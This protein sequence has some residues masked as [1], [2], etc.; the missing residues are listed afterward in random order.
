MSIA[1]RRMIALSA[2]LVA[3]SAAA[4]DSD[5]AEWFPGGSSTQEVELFPFGF[6]GTWAPSDEACRDVDGVERMQIYPGG[7][8]FYEGGGRLERITQSGHDRT[9][10]V[11]LSFEGEGE[12]WDA[13]WLVELARGSNGMRVK[14]DDAEWKTYQRCN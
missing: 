12:F 13:V 1:V 8:D 6:R 5:Y 9:V 2:A 10:K 7:V 3:G 4:Q 14:E 11:K